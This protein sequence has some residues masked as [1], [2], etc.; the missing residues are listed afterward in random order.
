M[1]HYRPDVLLR[2]P[3]RWIYSLIVVT[4]WLAGTEEMWVIV[5]NCWILMISKGPQWSFGLLATSLLNRTS[6][7]VEYPQVMGNFPP[8]KAPHLVS[9]CWVTKSCQTLPPHELQH[10]RL[11]CS[12]LSPG[13]CSDTW[14]LSWLVSSVAQSCLTLRPHGLQ[15]ARLPCPSPT[16]GA[17][18]NSCSSSQWCHP[19]ISS[20]GILYLV[21]WYLGCSNSGK[22]FFKG[23]DTELFR[24]SGLYSPCSAQLCSCSMKGP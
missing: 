6:A 5:I 17:Y 13:V 24:F 18:S 3:W 7:Y 4:I 12:S 10:A 19:T 11:P 15:H 22:L 8:P 14:Y 9:C 23:P 16:P 2:L 21:S 1:K 20:S